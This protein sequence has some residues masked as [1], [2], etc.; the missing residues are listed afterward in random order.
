[1]ANPI[2]HITPFSL[3]DYPDKIA[4][5]VWFAGCNMRC[6]YCYNIDIVKGKGRMS[7]DEVLEFLDTRK[8]LLDAVV[9]SGGECMLHIRIEQF[10]KNIKLRNMLVKIDT[11]GSNPRALSRLLRE[12]LVDYVAL[13]FKALQDRFHKITGS[14]H[15]RNFEKTLDLLIHNTVPFEVRTTVHSKLID[16]NYLKQMVAYLKNKGYSGKYYLQ[17]FFNDT[18]T[19]GEMENDYTAIPVDSLQ[20]FGIPVCLRTT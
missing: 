2:Y 4:C 6:L 13:D 3:L 19:L 12:N 10:I 11:N 14:D 9:L 7:Y 1:M 16:E 17:N 8:N 15:F 18:P 20:Q 5:I